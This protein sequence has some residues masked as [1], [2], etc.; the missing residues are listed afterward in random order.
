M[1]LS[2]KTAIGIAGVLVVGASVGGSVAY[3]RRLDHR[4]LEAV[5]PTTA[6]QPAQLVGTLRRVTAVHPDLELF[7]LPRTEDGNAASIL[8]TGN[9]EGDAERLS[10]LERLHQQLLRHDSLTPDDRALWAEAITDPDLERFITAA[11]QQHYD[12]FDLLLANA[13]SLPE[14][15]LTNI[16]LPDY[17]SVRTMALAVTLRAHRHRV[18]GDLDAAGRDIGAVMSVGLHMLTSSPTIVG[19]MTGRAMLEPAVTELAHYWSAR[20]DIRVEEQVSWLGLWASRNA[21]P[22]ELLSFLP[23]L[24]DSALAVAGDTSQLTAVRVQALGAIAV[25]QVL[26]AKHLFSGI[27]RRWVDGVEGLAATED[28][29]VARAAEITAETLRWFDD[30]GSLGRLRFIRSRLSSGG[31]AVGR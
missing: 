12:G 13:D 8:L 16:T 29:Q 23:S 22:S 31:K 9:A 5:S 17:T 20:E 24:P 28:P 14:P 18:R 10:N 30:M 4:F 19:S 2:P 26:R 21:D 11:R 7:I 1:K 15:K 25:A 3:V 6:G 27:E